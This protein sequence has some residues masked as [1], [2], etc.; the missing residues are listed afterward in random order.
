MIDPHINCDESLEMVKSLSEVS[1]NLTKYV[2]WR[3]SVS[4]AMS[5]YVRGSRRYFAA[6]T[7]LRNKIRNYARFRNYYSIYLPDVK[8]ELMF[9]FVL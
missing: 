2:S 7:I 1:A 6:L 5:S 8:N 4:N 9:L 3:E